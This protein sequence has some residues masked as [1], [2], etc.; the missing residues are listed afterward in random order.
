MK[1]SKP[2]EDTR[3]AYVPKRIWG[4]TGLAMRARMYDIPLEE[5]KRSPSM[6]K[7]LEQEVCVGCLGVQLME[8]EMEVDDGDEE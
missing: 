1:I 8:E 5:Q 4:K 2:R 6:A 7:L 3:G